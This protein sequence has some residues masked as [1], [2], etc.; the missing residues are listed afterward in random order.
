MTAP[1]G[2]VKGQAKALGLLARLLESGRLPSALLFHGPEGVGKTLAA[3]EFG[4]ALLCGERGG[5]APCG[6]CPACAAS[7]QGRHPDLKRVDAA[8]QASLLDEEE[9]RQRTWRVKTIRHLR[10]DMEMHSLL[11]SW[12]T[13]VIEDAEK[14]EPEA[15]NALLK[16]VEEPPEKTLWILTTSQKDRVM[17]TIQSRCFH[18]GFAP[19]PD[20]IIKEILINNGCER[21]HAERLASLAEGS[22]SRAL[23]L[24]KTPGW[25]DSLTAGP[26]APFAAADALPRDLAEARRQAELALFSLAQSLR[27]KNINGELPF[28]RIEGP[29]RQIARSRQALRSNADPRTALA[30]AAMSCEGLA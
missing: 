5:A 17:K 22:A 6:A 30:L 28:R 26:A 3:L 14:L 20:E 8:Y 29:L 11:G 4:R 13:A 24:A 25:P 7:A 12:K 10:R 18:I 16:I 1:A 19:L 27:L 9:G 23:E 2:A 21:S 15:A